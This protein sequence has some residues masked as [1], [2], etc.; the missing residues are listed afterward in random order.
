MNM[1]NQ[2][3]RLDTCISRR[4][5]LKLAAGTAV[6]AAMFHM[7][8][9]SYAKESV[10]W[11]KSL[12]P[13]L[14]AALPTDPLAAAR[15]S[16]LVRQGYDGILD[17]VGTIGDKRL[18]AAVLKLIKDPVPTFMQ[19]YSSPSLI[20]RAYAVLA[21]KGLIDTSKISADH[22]LPPFAG[23][24]PQPFMTA[25]GSGYG[26]H[27]A[28]PGGLATHVGTNLHITNYICKTYE[29]VFCYSVNRD[30]AIAGQALHDIEKPFVFQWQ[31][32]GS[33]LKEYTIA[34]QGAHHVIS[35]AEVMYRGFP[36]EEIVAQ[37]CAHGAPSSPKDEGDVVGWLKAA[38]ILAGKDPIACGYL[39]ASGD[40]LPQPHHQEGYIVH[41]G[42]H[43][44]VLSVPAS[45]KSVAALRKIA[46]QD[47]GMADADLKG[48]KF[49]SFRNYIG[50]QQSFM[51]LN[52]L[53]AEA[54][55]FEKVRK[56]V[57]DVVQ[58]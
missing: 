36:A 20:A 12:K 10:A 1:E 21:N 17:M 3:G 7:P 33:S 2:T 5:F 22:L 14:Y 53:E 57:R 4:G 44:W 9:F 38:A 11:Q 41:L 50:A 42:D 19:E 45:Q 8:S 30:V 24:S 32:D 27:H 18:Q 40:K 56:A 54:H 48:L 16:Q 58:L 25:P 23:K 49:N 28:Y 34:G 13:V 26:S 47:Y 46:V 43:D 35:L 29:E 15:A 39:D 37:A 31:D 55:G 6:G 52:M 51:Y